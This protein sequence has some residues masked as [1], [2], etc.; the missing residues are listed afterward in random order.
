ME[1]KPSS[2][3]KKSDYVPNNLLLQWHITERCNLRCKHCYQAGQKSEE[4][5][6]DGLLSILDQF[7][8]TLDHFSSVAGRRIRGHITVTG[9]EPFVRKDFVELLTEFNENKGAFTFAIL[10]NGTLV[11]E[12]IAGFLGEINPRFVQVSIEGRAETHEK[13]RGIGSYDCAIESLKL[14]RKAGVRT[15]VSFTAHSD[16]FSE[17]PDVAKT[18]RKL[19]VSRLWS[20]RLIPTGQCTELKTLSKE[21]IKEFFLLMRDA[22]RKALA[23]PFSKT[24]ISM[25]RALQFLAGDGKPYTCTAGDSLITVM[26]NGDVYPC[27]RMPIKVGN[28]LDKSLLEIYYGEGILQKLRNDDVI[29]EACTNCFYSKMCR[30]GLKCLSYAVYGDP[31]RRDPGCWLS[32]PSKSHLPS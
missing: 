18:C 11:N 17:F 23:S 20:D 19:G 13:I 31:F 22:R 21:E 2:R 27:R 4:L 24:E 9:G 8:E 32:K 26:P 28:L 14:L 15:M 5:D 6:L 16:N 29:D 7:K 12:E 30:G 25:H 10:T 1:H 3:C